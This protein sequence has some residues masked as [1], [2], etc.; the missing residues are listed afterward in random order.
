MIDNSE[1]TKSELMNFGGEKVM[2]LINNVYRKEFYDLI[3]LTPVCFKQCINVIKKIQ[4]FRILRSA[5]A[6]SVERQQEII[7][8]LIKKSKIMGRC[9]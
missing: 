5:N 2:A 8:E 1:K 9:V 7:N 6:F 3:G 4:V